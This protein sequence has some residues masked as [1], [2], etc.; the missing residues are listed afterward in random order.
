MVYRGRVEKGVVVFEGSAALPEGTRVLMEPEA[1][2]GPVGSI[3][4]ILGSGAHW[5]G[6]A[7]EMDQLLA[8]LREMKQAELRQQ[9]REAG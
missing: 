3:E 6:S 9:T 8:D 7:E 2:A 1:T 5:H 4:A